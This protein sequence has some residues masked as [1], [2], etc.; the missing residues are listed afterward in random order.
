MRIS[1]L[2]LFLL[3][4]LSASC[5]QK[6]N[7]KKWLEN[8]DINDIKS[9][10]RTMVNDIINNHLRK[11]MTKKDI[12]VLLGKPSFD[13]VKTYLPN[14]VKFPDSLT[15]QNIYSLNISEEKR[16]QLKK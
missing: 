13:E 1:V 12:L 5:Q 10:R 9:P 7:Q 8:G 2:M 3:C 11:G 6:F 14:N 4:F 15:Y 16:K